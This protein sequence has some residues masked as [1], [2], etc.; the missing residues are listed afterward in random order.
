MHEVSL[1]RSI[2]RTLEDE[3]PAEKMD[4]LVQVSLKVGLL[5]NVEPVLMQTAFQALT[6]TEKKYEE[7]SLE[8]EIV[9]VAVYCSSC[10]HTSEVQQYKFV[11]E[12]CGQLNNNVVQGTELLI[13]QVYFSENE[14]LIVDS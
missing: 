1:V 3:F 5:S 13:H 7:V 2:F 6:E 9:P 8:I 14:T 12:V 4:R 11:C 10:D